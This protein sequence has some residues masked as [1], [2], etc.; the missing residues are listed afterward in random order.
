MLAQSFFANLQIPK[1]TTSTRHAPMAGREDRGFWHWPNR[2][3]LVAGGKRDGAKG[4]HIS[5]WWK[6]PGQVRWIR[7]ATAVRAPIGWSIGATSTVRSD[8]PCG[9]QHRVNESFLLFQM[10]MSEEGNGHRRQS[11]NC[12]GHWVRHRAESGEG[13]RALDDER[14]ARYKPCQQKSQKRSRYAYKQKSPF[15]VTNVPLP[16]IKC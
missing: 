8:V 2:D 10:F 12:G 3:G 5:C 7:W 14:V 16:W 6:A 11:Q 1:S 15:I 4:R 13:G 9:H